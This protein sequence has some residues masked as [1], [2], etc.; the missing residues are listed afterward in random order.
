MISNYKFRTEEIKNLSKDMVI[1]TDSREKNNL[2]ITEYFK[3]QGIP[4]QDTKLDYGDYSFMLPKESGHFSEDLYFHRD[5]VI[6]RKNSL[7]ELSTN[8][9]QGRERFERELMRASND[10]CKIFL[11]VEESAG[12]GGI[13]QQ[14]YDTQLKPVSYMASLKSFE[15]R[16]DLH[17]EFINKQYSG[18]M[19]WNTLYYYMRERLK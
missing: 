17:I 7:E 3:S 6:E 4:Y 10:K 2:H 13:L 11:M 18:Y 9:A 19:I 12:Y 1:L 16:Y 15:N 5:I 8:L 14:S